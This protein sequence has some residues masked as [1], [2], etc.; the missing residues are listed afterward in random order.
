MADIGNIQPLQPTY[1]KRRTD[2]VE[3]DLEQNEQNRG[4]PRPHK[5]I[6]ED[7]DGKPHVDEFA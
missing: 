4:Q 6:D 7:D 5:D 2:R 1:P 3:K